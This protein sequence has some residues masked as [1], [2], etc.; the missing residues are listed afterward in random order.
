MPNTQA[1]QRAVGAPMP[2]D[3]AAQSKR[4]RKE[5]RSQL[6]RE[7]WKYGGTWN[8]YAWRVRPEGMRFVRRR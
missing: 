3:G 1:K 2:L 5:K 4:T 6:T 7:D 8:A